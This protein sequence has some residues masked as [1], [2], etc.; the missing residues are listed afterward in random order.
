MARILG[1][2]N[3]ITGCSI[4]SSGIAT[5]DAI[6][7]GRAKEAAV[8][9]N[10]AGATT[11]TYSNMDVSF[12]VST[13]KDGSYVNY[14]DTANALLTSIVSIDSSQTGRIYKFD[15]PLVPWMKVIVTATTNNTITLD[16]VKLI[17]DE[18]N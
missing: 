15:A 2:Y 5:S 10:I 6:P 7:I 3:A 11:G 17:S 16:S 14:A 13:E 18:K 1:M 4:T 9:V 12:S 8:Q